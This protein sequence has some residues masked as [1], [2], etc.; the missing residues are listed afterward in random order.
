[1][2]DAND[3]TIKI[4]F[5]IELKCLALNTEYDGGYTVCSEDQILFLP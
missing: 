4:L 2:T 1:M 5:F 3:L